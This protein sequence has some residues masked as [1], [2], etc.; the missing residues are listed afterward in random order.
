MHSAGARVK[1]YEYLKWNIVW[2]N[3]R[4]GNKALELNLATRSIER[5]ALH[6]MFLT[7]CA[8]CHI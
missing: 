1:K 7:Y 8:I 6:I 4:M 3:N 5:I 2:E